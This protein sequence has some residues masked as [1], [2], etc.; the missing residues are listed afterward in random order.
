MVWV[1][2]AGTVYM[3]CYTVALLLHDLCTLSN[4][5]TL[6]RSISFPLANVIRDAMTTLAWGLPLEY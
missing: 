1:Y 5:L 2:N 3:A 4:I 6:Y